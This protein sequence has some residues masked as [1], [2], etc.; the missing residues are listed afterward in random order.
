[1]LCILC[2]R[3]TNYYKQLGIKV[4]ANQQ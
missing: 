1:M 4:Q 2:Y 3:G